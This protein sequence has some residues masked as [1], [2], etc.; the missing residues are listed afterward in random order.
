LL[1]GARQPVAPAASTSRTFSAKCLAVRITFA[2]YL[3]GTCRRFQEVAQSVAAHHLSDNAEPK[4]G[5]HKPRAGILS[6]YRHLIPRLQHGSNDR[7][8]RFGG[9]TLT[10]E[11]RTEV[12]PEFERFWIMPRSS[13]AARTRP[14]GSSV[15]VSVRNLFPSGY[16]A[17]SGLRLDVRQRTRR[18]S[19]GSRR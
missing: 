8:T 16:H 10:T 5:R 7:A 9:E 11:P 6:H 15:C 1:A 2:T 4:L 3:P 19:S 13:R 17:V 12:I 14:S 18:Q